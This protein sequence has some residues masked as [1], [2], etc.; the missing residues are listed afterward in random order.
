VWIERILEGLS[1]GL[2]AVSVLIPI[3]SFAIAWSW[4]KPALM[5]QAEIEEV[6]VEE[7]EHPPEL[8]EQEYDEPRY[9]ASTIVRPPQVVRREDVDE[10]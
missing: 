2:F 6:E 8:P 10:D 4:L 9:T 3:F 5:K 7:Y 1:W